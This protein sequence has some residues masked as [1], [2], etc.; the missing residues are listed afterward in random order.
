MLKDASALV[1]LS[2]ILFSCYWNQQITSR[3]NPKASILLVGPGQ[4]KLLNFPLPMWE[5]LTKSKA[6]KIMTCL[7]LVSER[8]RIP[9]L[10]FP[11]MACPQA[12]TNG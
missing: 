4:W 10:W 6:L 2:E 1:V 5:V 3:N 12:T 7:S 8:I 11:A 9:T